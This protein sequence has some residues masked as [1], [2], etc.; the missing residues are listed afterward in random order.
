MARGLKFWLLKVHTVQP[1]S[2]ST[3]GACS[4][5][6]TV[7]D[8]SKYNV[9]IDMIENDLCCKKAFQTNVIEIKYNCAKRYHILWTN[10]AKGII[11]FLQ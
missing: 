5:V 9:R 7:L 11:F 8:E 2:F 3:V 1:D 10:C 4:T 6:A